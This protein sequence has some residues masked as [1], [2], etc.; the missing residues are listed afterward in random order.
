MSTQ[1]TSKHISIT[2]L[3]GCLI[4]TLDLGY[5]LE[6]PWMSGF[7]AERVSDQ[8]L[9][10]LSQKLGNWEKFGFARPEF[11]ESEYGKTDRAPR[12]TFAKRHA[13]RLLPLQMRIPQPAKFT[14]RNLTFYA[15]TVCI[16]PQGALSVRILFKLEPNTVLSAEETIT[17]YNHMLVKVPNLSRNTITNF[18]AFWNASPISSTQLVSPSSELLEEVLHSYEIIDFD[19]N[20]RSDNEQEEIRSVKNIYKDVDI[21]PACELAAIS[22]MSPVSCKALNDT[23]LIEFFDTDIGSRDDELWAIN[24]DRM[25][26]RHPDRRSIY[27]KAFFSDIKMA[28]EILATQQATFDFL[29]EWVA[30]RR[31]A[32]VGQM[33]EYRG[34]TLKEKNDFQ[35]QFGEVMHITQ[36]LIEP[37]LL[38][39][40]VRHAFYIQVVSRVAKCMEIQESNERSSRALQDFA[41]LI[42]TVS[43]YQNAEL[44]ATLGNLQVQFAKSAKRIGIATIWITVLAIILT[45]L[46]VYMAIQSSR[47]SPT[48]PNTTPTQAVR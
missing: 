2:L 11:L 35:M 44:S 28:S 39:K 20:L 27:N 30:K 42:E 1:Q 24:K 33:L 38:Q 43:G 14:E 7:I 23:K 19:F 15:D 17:D 31:K 10:E 6:D 40:N 4:F 36:L 46:Q 32:M 16:S 25:I 9:T 5:L 47:Q 48:L 37:V 21:V 12:N 41:Q 18:V 34:L 22:K 26:R 8:W 29:E 13:K 3:E 45:L